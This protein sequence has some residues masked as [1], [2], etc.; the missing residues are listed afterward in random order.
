LKKNEINFAKIKTM[1]IAILFVLSLLN[2][3]HKNSSA[4][5]TKGICAHR[6]AMATHPENTIVAFKE[7]IRLGV[8][9]IEFDVF[10]TKDGAL[11]VIHD[12]TLDR[13]TNG[14]GKVA[15]FTLAEI[16]SL[17]AGSWKGPEFF[18]E[19]V[20]TFDEVLQIMPRNIWLNI[21][22]KD[23]P[24]VGEEIAL[25]LFKSGRLPQAFLA[26]NLETKAVAQLVV[27]GLLV[28]NM[29]RQEQ[30]KVYVDQTIANKANFI[31]L[32]KT[33][34]ESLGPLLADLHQHQINVNYFGTD[35]PEKI[36][37]LLN[38]GVNFV[39]VNNPGPAMNV[40]A[41]LGIESVVPEF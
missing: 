18:G 35:D 5:P 16:K 32:R 7:A 38:A 2:C 37:A 1:I 31:Q 33:Q 17:D 36:T 3:S 6:G 27:P 20:P 8:H 13:T 10:K 11:V 24:E 28:C 22:L 39:L 19:K 15:D 4:L 26:C 40:A 9:M 30:D 12:K 34:L 14:S 25:K 23:S 21:H 41:E 29:E